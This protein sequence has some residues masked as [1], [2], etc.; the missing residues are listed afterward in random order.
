MKTSSLS[1]VFFSCWTSALTFQGGSKG[2]LDDSDCVPLG[3]KFACF[4]YKCLNWV[5][6]QEGVV[7]CARDK[8]C[9]E[10][11]RCYKHHNLREVS[12]GLCFPSAQLSTCSEHSECDSSSLSFCCGHRCCPETYFRQWQDF[13][14]V[15]DQQCQTWNTGLSCCSD[16][17]CCDEKEGVTVEA[18]TYD[19]YDQAEILDGTDEGEEE[20]ESSEQPEVGARAQEEEEETSTTFQLSPISSLQDEEVEEEV[21]SSTPTFD[22]D[23]EEKV[24]VIAEDEEVNATDFEIENVNASDIDIANVSVTVDV[25]DS[26]EKTF[27]YTSSE[28]GSSAQSEKTGFDTIGKD[29]TDDKEEFLLRIDSIETSDNRSVGTNLTDNE[30]EGIY[31]EVAVDA[32]EDSFMEDMEIETDGG[33]GEVKEIDESIGSSFDAMFSPQRNR[34]RSLA[35][36]LA[37]TLATF[38]LI[39]C[40][41]L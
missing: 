21:S 12:T 31:L 6:K 7:H 25:I 9:G 41:L 30:A 28:N 18:P 16:S 24:P 33:G 39:Q 4:F 3:H 32:A 14:C 2:C 26:A 38:L 37:T 20:E 22:W 35:S 23:W 13:S 27:I 40:P 29:Q 8:E 36:S 5:D 15:T 17:R 11:S 34:A 1:L 10:G 19:Y